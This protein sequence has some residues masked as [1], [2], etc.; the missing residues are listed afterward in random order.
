MAF[1]PYNTGKPQVIA[2]KAFF[3][4]SRSTASTNRKMDLW[5]TSKQNDFYERNRCV[6]GDTLVDY[7]SH[8]YHGKGY[9]QKPE[10]S[11]TA[12]WHRLNKL[13]NG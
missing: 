10:K 8:A 1:K 11:F 3:L 5:H 7:G 6:Q 9:S 12:R 13:S 2:A 4:V